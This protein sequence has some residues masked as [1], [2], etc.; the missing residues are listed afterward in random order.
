M[1]LGLILQAVNP[2]YFF[3]ILHMQCCV[4]LGN[5]NV[6]SRKSFRATPSC[7]KRKN[8]HNDKK[9]FKT[10]KPTLPLFSG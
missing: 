6:F 5:F 7:Y 1:M 4:P 9:R 2:G 10:F 3:D 8:F